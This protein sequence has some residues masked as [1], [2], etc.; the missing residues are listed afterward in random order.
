MRPDHC[1]QVKASGFF[2]EHGLKGSFKG[3]SFLFH[4][5]KGPWNGCTDET[6]HFK[7]Q[8]FPFTHLTLFVSGKGT[9][10]LLP[11]S[12]QN[13]FTALQGPQVT[14]QLGVLVHAFAV[15]NAIERESG[16]EVQSKSIPTIHGIGTR[17]TQQ[18]HIQAIE[19]PIWSVDWSTAT[20]NGSFQD[21]N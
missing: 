16:A 12:I 18:S 21:S 5:L 15:K 2:S 1:V 8:Q 3:T 4:H 11:A 7:V 6:N 17:S 14:W 13:E 9:T 10:Q 20:F 19:N